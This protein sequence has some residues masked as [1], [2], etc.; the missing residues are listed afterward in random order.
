M[1]DTPDDK[2]RSLVDRLTDELSLGE[3][4]EVLQCALARATQLALGQRAEADTG[5]HRDSVEAEQAPAGG[6][7]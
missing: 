6:G 3:T 7:E 1:T 5:E 2:A 4:V